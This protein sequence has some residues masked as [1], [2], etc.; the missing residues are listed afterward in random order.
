V[1][2]ST[3]LCDSVVSLHQPPQTSEPPATGARDVGWS[4]VRLLV[5]ECDRMLVLTVRVAV[6]EEGAT[7]AI[8][9]GLPGRPSRLAVDGGARELSLHLIVE[10]WTGEGWDGATS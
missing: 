7:Q 1:E 3:S 4:W 6:G 9:R 5:D 2:A 8:T 10:R